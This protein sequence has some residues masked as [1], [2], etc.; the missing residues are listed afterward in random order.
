MPKTPR[1]PRTP[2]QKIKNRERVRRFQ[3]RH[4]PLTPLIETFE[5]GNG[6]MTVEREGLLRQRFPVPKAT[7]HLLTER[8]RTVLKGKVR[9]S[10]GWVRM[11][12]IMSETGMTMEEFV[13]QLSVEELVRGKFRDKNGKMQ[14][15]SPKWVPREFHRACLQEL[16]R[17]G[18]HMWQEN[19]LAAIQAMTNIATGQGEIG[20]MAT[21]AERLKAAQFVVERMEGKVPERLVITEDKPW[22]T[23]LDGIVAEVPAE[24]I[25]RGR[26]A[27]EAAQVVEG[28]L[29]DVA[30]EEDETPPEPVRSRRRRVQR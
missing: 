14:G 7:Q 5:N 4:D 21:P 22:Q 2:E 12:K 8:Q 1:K 23:V 19:Y 6:G 26:I 17:R 24:A 3:K 30:V 13:Q 27:L 18:R 10:R 9:M 16:M 11:E 25:E 20:Q 15:R 28:E 29:V